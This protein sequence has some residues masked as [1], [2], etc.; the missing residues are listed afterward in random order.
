MSLDQATAFYAEHA[1]M[2]PANARAEAVKNSMF[3]GAA[4]MYWLGTRAIHALRA[5]QAAR[6]GSAFS[7]RAFHDAFLSFGALPVP[8]IASLMSAP[9]SA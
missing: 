4:V 6:G 3:P 9:A 7:L 2:P 8:M 5:E 1:Q